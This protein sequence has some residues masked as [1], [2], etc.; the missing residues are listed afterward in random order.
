M[1]APEAAPIRHPDRFFI[2]GEWVKPSSDAKLSVYDSGSEDLLLSVAE[3]QAGISEVRPAPDGGLTFSAAGPGAVGA[4]SLSL[5]ESGALIEELSRRH[6]TLEDLFFS[7]TEGDAAGSPS[8]APDP[9][10]AQ[11]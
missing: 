5:V 9:E 6:A 3:A 7:L 11:A 2:N 1:S 4:L 8:A 10:P